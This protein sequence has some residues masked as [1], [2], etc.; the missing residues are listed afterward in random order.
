[1]SHSL[2]QG[3]PGLGTLGLPEPALRALCLEAGFG[4]VERAPFAVPF[5]VLYVVTP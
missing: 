4:R 3:G 1:M 2:A 5:N